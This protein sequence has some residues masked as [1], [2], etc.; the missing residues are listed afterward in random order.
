MALDSHWQGFSVAF[1]Y[2]KRQSEDILRMFF[3]A[4]KVKACVVSCKVF[5]SNMAPQF[6]NAWHH[7][8]GSCK[9]RLYCAWHMDKSF[10]DNSKRLIKDNAELTT[11]LYKQLRILRNEQ[12]IGD[13]SGLSACTV[14]KQLRNDCI[15]QILQVSLCILRSFV[16]L[17]L[18]CLV[19]CQY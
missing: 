6:H 3:E 2:S 10:R 16:E 5:M 13:C 1:L 19:W 9:N 4:I 12:D 15:C 7:V 11:Q 17:L 18:P 14:G 8:M